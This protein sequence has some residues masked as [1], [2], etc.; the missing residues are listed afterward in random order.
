MDL[1]FFE[2][3]FLKWNRFDFLI[4]FIGIFGLV[5]VFVAGFIDTL[6][7]INVNVWNFYGFLNYFGGASVSLSL[8]YFLLI[9]YFGCLKNGVKS[10]VERATV[11]EKWFANVG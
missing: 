9:K 10:S 7:P 4:F 6:N 1:D 8:T 3:D 2:L 11:K 5:L